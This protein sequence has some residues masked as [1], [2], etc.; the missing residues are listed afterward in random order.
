MSGTDIEPSQTPRRVRLR[1]R[2]A[3]WTPGPVRALVRRL[4]RPRRS[5]P[6]TGGRDLP[7]AI[8]VGIGLASVFAGALWW[9]P[10]A[11]TVVIGLLTT[12]AYVELRHVLR[13]AGGDLDVLVLVAATSV[14]LLG[15]YH[16]GHAG[17]VI[18]VLVL[19]VGAFLWHAADTERAHVASTVATTVLYGLWIGF[20]ASYAVLLIL[21]PSGGIVVVAAVIGAAVLAD[22]GAFAVGVKWGRHPVA[23]RLSPNKTWEGLAGGLASAT[24]VGVIVLPLLDGP[25][26]LRSAAVVTFACGLAAFLGDLV[27]SMMKRDL[28]VK[29]LGE[30]LPGH[31]GILDRVDGI[32]FALPVGHYA[33]ELLT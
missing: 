17:Q 33:I 6:Q 8:A 22:T 11:F 25:F 14:M 21:R 9:N 20:L 13:G 19:V 30:V 16:A 23:P 28:G 1:R 2:L 3:R 7:V 18:G 26:D 4:R 31:G 5:R 27:E 12:I 24:I 15:A 10:I 29:D 32:L